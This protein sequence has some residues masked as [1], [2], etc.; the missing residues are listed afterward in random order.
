MPGTFPPPS[1]WKETSTVSDPGV[2]HG[3]CVTHVPWRMPGSLARNGG[4]NVPGIPG[5][6]A[7]H[8]FTYLARGPCSKCT[9]MWSR[10]S[11]MQNDMFMY[12]WTCWIWIACGYGSSVWPFLNTD[13]ITANQ[14]T[15]HLWSFDFDIPI[16]YSSGHMAGMAIYT[17][18]DITGATH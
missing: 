8:N 12:L 11:F 18:N 9:K 7:T 3:T 16:V 15:S 1:T 13:R 14:V 4:E 2:H 5:A 17:V 10:V 6:C